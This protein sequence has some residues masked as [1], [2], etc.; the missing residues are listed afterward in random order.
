M[1]YGNVSV[2]IND[3]VKF[4]A[5]YT[6][7]SLGAILNASCRIWF[8]DTSSWSNMSWNSTDSIYDYSRVLN[9]SRLYDYNISCEKVGFGS[10]NLKDGNYE[11]VLTTLYNS[12]VTDEFRQKFTIGKRSVFLTGDVIGWFGEKKLWELLMIFSIIIFIVLAWWLLRNLRKRRK[13]KITKGIKRFDKLLS[14]KKNSIMK[15]RKKRRK[16]RGKSLRKVKK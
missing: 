5:N 16:S 1:K 4:F 12:N 6:N 11:F 13:R 7:I 10:L 2:S 15:R 14:K 9:E 8:N 3:T